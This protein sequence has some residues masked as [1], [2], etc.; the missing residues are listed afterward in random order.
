MVITN[1]GCN[2][3]SS[4]IFS[5]SNE[6]STT[7]IYHHDYNDVTI[8]VNKHWRYLRVHYNRVWLYF[9]W[10]FLALQWVWLRGRW[11]ICV[12]SFSFSVVIPGRMFKTFQVKSSHNRKLPHCQLFGG[13]LKLRMTILSCWS[14]FRFTFEKTWLILKFSSTGGPWYLRF[15]LFTENHKY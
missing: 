6:Y 12:T 9:V 13:F 1:Y 14:K 8:I 10:V 2:E 3:Q 11:N 4:W 7:Y 15:W 5:V